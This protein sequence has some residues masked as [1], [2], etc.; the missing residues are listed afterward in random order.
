[1]GKRGDNKPIFTLYD[2]KILK[3][4]IKNKELKIGEI[5]DKTNGTNAHIRERINRLEEYGLL[6]E[7]SRGGRAI[8]ISITPSKK[9]FVKKLLNFGGKFL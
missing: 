5:E 8:F 4:L 9:I 3:C 6:K 7:N 1:M 2:F